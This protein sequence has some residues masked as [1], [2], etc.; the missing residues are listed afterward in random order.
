MVRSQHCSV[1][2]TRFGNWESVRP[3]MSSFMFAREPIDSARRLCLGCKILR[4]A[5][6]PITYAAYPGETPVFSSGKEIEGWKKVTAALPGLPEAASGNVWMA[7]V[8]DRFFTLYDAEGLLPR[9]RSAGFIPL[10]RW[11]S[12]PASLSQG[13]I[14]ELAECRR[15]GDHC[16]SASC[17]DFECAAVGIG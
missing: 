16:P 6:R 14:E 13:P 12:Q 7:D 1:L 8:S 15:R 9:A 5:I 4:R 3:K 17:L 10:R 2:V 11:Q